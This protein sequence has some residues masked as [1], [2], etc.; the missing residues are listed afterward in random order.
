MPRCLH[1][2]SSR[3]RKSSGSLRTG[4]RIVANP[5]TGNAKRWRP[6]CHVVCIVTVAGL[7]RVRA[8]LRTGSRIVANPAT[9]NAIRW[10]PPCYVCPDADCGSDQVGRHRSNLGVAENV[11]DQVAFL[12]LI[13][14]ANQK[15]DAAGVVNGIADLLAAA[16]HFD[17]GQTKSVGVNSCD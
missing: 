17:H 5:A 2:N 1:R 4:S 10:R 14:D 3:T 15:L 7:A 8:A 12:D 9:G 6:P 13:T 11:C 16:T